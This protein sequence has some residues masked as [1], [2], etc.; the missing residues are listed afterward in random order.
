MRWRQFLTPVAS[1]NFEQCKTYLDGISAGDVTILDVRQPTEYQEGH[2]PGAKL[3][4]LPQL[5][6]RI[7]ELD[8]KKTTIVYCAVGGRSRVAAQM[9]AGK[10][11]GQVFNLTGGI[12]AWN[13]QTA[14]GSEDMGLMLFNGQESVAQCLAIAYALEGG[15]REFYESM[16]ARVTNSE[17]RNLFTKL[18]SIEV[19]HQDR[20]YTE[21]TKLKD[22]TIDKETFQNKVVDQMAEGGLT[23]KEYSQLYN[24]DWESVLD[25]ASTAMAIEAQALDLYLRASRRSQNQEVQ[26]VLKQIANEE[27]S[28][29]AQLGKLIETL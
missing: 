6:E 12:R 28:H 22:T 27:T 9:L 29:M 25:I 19:K 15:L 20:L 16:T 3:I 18:A 24:P 23:T 5:G 13:D 21:Y 7:T 14:L 1:L 10:G 17:A 11:F 2:I 26:N 8:P 4:P